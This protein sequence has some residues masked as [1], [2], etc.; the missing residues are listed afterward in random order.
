MSCAGGILVPP[1]QPQAGSI[2]MIRSR[3]TDRSIDQACRET[4]GNQSQ[5]L[6]LPGLQ[7]AHLVHLPR[8]LKIR[9]PRDRMEAGDQRLDAAHCA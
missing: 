4:G 9:E 5:T 2:A 3:T 1:A 8:A 7:G 6:E